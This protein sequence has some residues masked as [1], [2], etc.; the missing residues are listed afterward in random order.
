[1]MA[2]IPD[3]NSLAGQQPIL[4]PIPLNNDFSIPKFASITRHSLRMDY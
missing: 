2:A 4:A 3:W 1:M